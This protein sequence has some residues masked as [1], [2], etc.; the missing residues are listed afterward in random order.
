MATYYYCLQE[1]CYDSVSGALYDR[2]PMAGTPFIMNGELIADYTDAEA[3]QYCCFDHRDSCELFM[4]RRPPDTCS[5]Y[6]PF[7]AGE[8]QTLKVLITSFST[9]VHS[10]FKET[11]WFFPAHS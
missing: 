5:D 7:L 6:N 2:K 1:C 3:L 9:L 10:S 11:K 4:D 8:T